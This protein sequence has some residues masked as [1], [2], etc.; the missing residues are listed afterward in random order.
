MEARELL[1]PSPHR[2][3]LIAAGAVVLTVGVTLEEI[4]LAGDLGAG[5]HLAILAVCGA[6]FYWLGVQAPNE[7]GTPPAYQSVLLVTGLGLL[8][9]ALLRLADM[10]G[11]DFGGFPAGAIA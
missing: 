2:G 4:R 9:A 5:A 3:P 10:L 6:L 11:A 1:R 7:D 8:F